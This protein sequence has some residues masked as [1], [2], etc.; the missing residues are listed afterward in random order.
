MR[1]S[2]L[3]LVACIALA[4]E[5][6]PSASG[7]DPAALELDA[8]ALRVSAI[9]GLE[10]AV[11][12]PVVAESLGLAPALERPELEPAIERLLARLGADPRLSE[13]ADRLFAELQD[14]PAMRAALLDYAR[15]NPDLELSALTEGFV[16]YVD[17]RLTRPA[18]ATAIESRLRARLRTAEPALARTLVREAGGAE[19]L[20]T[21]ILV[22]FAEGRVRAGLEARLGKDPAALQERLRERL[23]DPR[24]L[25]YLVTALGE[26][27]RS[28]AG[29]LALRT[30]VDHER[31]ATLVAGALARAL[32]DPAVRERSEAL[33]ALALAEPLDARAFERK[34]GGLLDEPALV[35]EAEALLA[36]LAREAYVREQVGALAGA[37]VAG[38]SFAE[39]LLDALD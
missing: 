5:R 17:A 14:S 21:A 13:V 32:E 35:R 15:A 37:V 38:P 7:P 25:A 12:D 9:A 31:T 1:A 18:I 28:E 8:G 23:S 2:A 10:A 6:E 24:R 26:P 27:L 19:L 22:S 11:D 39:P 33:F 20:A 29:A 30:I 3:A 4:C 16:A 34:L 36:A